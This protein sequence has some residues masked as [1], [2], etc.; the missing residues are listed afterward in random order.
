MKIKTY[1]E[2]WKDK[3]H[4][5]KEM[6]KYFQSIINGMPIA[7]K[8]LKFIDPEGNNIQGIIDVHQEY[9]D[10]P[11]DSIQHLLR[12]IKYAKDDIANFD[13]WESNKE[14]KKI[15]QKATKEINF[16]QRK[17]KNNQTE[18]PENIFTPLKKL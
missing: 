16:N 18:E 12:D 11:Q 15:L 7:I 4:N 10:S 9:D 14:T 6:I 17:N 1:R 2:M 8:A 5:C 13:Y 3:I